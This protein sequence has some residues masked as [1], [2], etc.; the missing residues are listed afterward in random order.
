LTVKQYDEMVEA[1]VVGKDRLE[2]IEGLLVAHMPRSRQH[3]AAGNVGLRI[4]SRVVPPGWHIIKRDPIAISDMSKLE[5]DL[6]VIRGDIEDYDGTD[7]TAADAAVVVEIGD[8]SDYWIQQGL[9]PIYA[10]SGMPVYWIINLVDRQLEVYS[11]P[12]GREYRRSQVFSLEQ[13][14]PVII[15]GVE[16]GRVRVADF[17]P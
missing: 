8:L 1:D 6:A 10:A 7:V 3:I 14:V 15:A 16:V 2:L 17:M 5:P 13:Y 11:E 12:E 4:L 9:R